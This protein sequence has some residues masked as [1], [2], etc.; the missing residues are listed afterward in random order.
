MCWTCKE[1]FYNLQ[2]GTHCLGKLFFRCSWNS[3]NGL[4]KFLGLNGVKKKG[5]RSSFWEEFSSHPLEGGVSY[6]KRHYFVQR[7]RSPNRLQ[8]YSIQELVS[9][10]Q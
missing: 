4:A 8:K 1:L 9:V 10:T 7:N 2:R 3:L 6:S 5:F